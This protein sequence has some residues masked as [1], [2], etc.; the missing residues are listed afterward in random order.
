[1][2]KLALNNGGCL[3][4]SRPRPNDGQL[5]GILHVVHKLNGSTTFSHDWADVSQV[6][7]SGRGYGILNTEKTGQQKV[8][9]LAFGKATNVSSGDGVDDD[10]EQHAA[11]TRVVAGV[12]ITSNGMPAKMLVGSVDMVRC[13]LG[14]GS[15]SLGSSC[16]F[17]RAAHCF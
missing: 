14:S 5:S 7:T 12:Q 17:T 3:G 9:Q 6:H 16:R 13:R 4:R 11:G 10:D 1:M 2:S 8:T 15:S